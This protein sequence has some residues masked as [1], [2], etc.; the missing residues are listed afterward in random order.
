MTVAILADVHGNLPALE[1]VLAE[2]DGADADLIVVAGDVDGGPFPAETI[3]LLR[4]LGDRARLVQG[5]ADRYLVEHVSG[6]DA[7]DRQVAWAAERL[8]PADADFLAAFEDT[9][10]VQV[11]GLGAVL[12]CHGS[13][14]SDEE[15]VTQRTPESRVAP[16]LAGVREDVVVCGHTHMQFDRALAGKRV[17]NGGSV[18]M[19][20]ADRP[21]AYWTLLGPDVELRRTEYDLDA[22]AERIRA[23]G[24]PDADEFIAQNL[25]V[26]P[27]AEEAMAVFEPDTAPG[28]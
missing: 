27:T 26:V 19:P 1:A 5:N 20:Y 11:D 7:H 10:S 22:A 28:T 8:S 23:T 17:V 15:M 24:W 6:R 16:M 14:R 25:L 12:V 13:P 2:V 9:V 21:G 18:G 4:S 3:A